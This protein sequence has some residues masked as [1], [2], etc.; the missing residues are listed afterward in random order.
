MNHFIYISVLIITLTSCLKDKALEPVDTSGSC[1]DTV[2]FSNEIQPLI[3][4]QSCNVS[5]CHDPATGMD[6]YI[7]DNHTQV[8]DN[9]D[10]IL[11]VINHEPGVTPMPYTQPKLADSLI[12]LFDCWVQQG[13]PN[14]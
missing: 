11:Q 12:Q 4:N 14:N 10:I 13:K 2:S 6:G 1:S 7:F 8:A 5:G 3:I 9:A